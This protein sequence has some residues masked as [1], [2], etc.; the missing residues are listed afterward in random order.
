MSENKYNDT[1]SYERHTP[2]LQDEAAKIPC[3]YC[4]KAIEFSELAEHQANC[5]RNPMVV[6]QRR[7]HGRHSSRGKKQAEGLGI[8]ESIHVLV[9]MMY[10]HTCC[11]MQE[12][13][14]TH[15]VESIYVYRIVGNFRGSKILQSVPWINIR[16]SYFCDVAIKD[17][18]CAMLN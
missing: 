1:P 17:K 15:S 16:G 9:R 7:I 5:D 10:V 6:E 3:E 14:Y 4:E 11:I 2:I 12:Y 18:Y 8:G 13:M